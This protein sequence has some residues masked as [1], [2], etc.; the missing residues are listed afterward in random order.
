MKPMVVCKS[1]LRAKLGKMRHYTNVVCCSLKIPPSSS[2][3]LDVV[4]L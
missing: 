1:A 2:S 4:V 3:Q